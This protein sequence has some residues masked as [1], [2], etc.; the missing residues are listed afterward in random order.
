[1]VEEDAIERISDLITGGQSIDG[2][3]AQVQTTTK[4][5]PDL[6]KYIAKSKM[7]A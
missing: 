5:S 2:T 7:T 6:I 3:V 4:L 1:M